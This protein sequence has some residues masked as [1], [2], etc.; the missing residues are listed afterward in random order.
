MD[1]KCRTLFVDLGTPVVA[2]ALL[3]ALLV[4]GVTLAPIAIERWSW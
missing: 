3:A 4:A 1:M 2:A